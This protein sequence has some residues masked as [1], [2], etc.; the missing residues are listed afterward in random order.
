MD[1]SRTI[2]VLDHNTAN[3]IPYRA[4][5]TPDELRLSKNVI[6]LGQRKLLISEIEFLTEVLS[7]NNATAM[8]VYAGAA[9]GSHIVHLAEMFPSI[10]WELYDTNKFAG[11]LHRHPNVNLYHEYLTPE[12]AA[13]SYHPGTTYFISDIRTQTDDDAIKRDNLLVNHILQALNPISAILKFRLPFSPGMTPFPAGQ[14]RLQPWTSHDS[15]EC[16]LICAQPYTLQDVN[17]TVHEEGMMAHN[18][19]RPIYR[20][21]ILPQ[22]LQSEFRSA[23]IT[24]NWDQHRE[25]QVVQNY[26]NKYNKDT[27]QVHRKIQCF[28]RPALMYAIK[29]MTHRV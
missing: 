18:L 11:P 4:I 1:L 14:I 13:K 15:T 12:L 9:P 8:V 22:R 10:R 21:G 26:S 24:A 3:R 27:D 23:G 19:Q 25:Y 20:N 6:H 17:H 28:M 16:R 7:T 5:L 29:Q 2:S